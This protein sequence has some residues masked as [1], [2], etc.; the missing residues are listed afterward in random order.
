ML[1]KH[2][3]VQNQEKSLWCILKYHW[4]AFMQMISLHKG[5]DWTAKEL[6]RN[7]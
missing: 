4:N 1:K 2:K 7:W 5:R 6:P 3:I